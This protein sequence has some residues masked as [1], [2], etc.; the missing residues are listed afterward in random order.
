MD[1]LLKPGEPLN[2]RLLSRLVLPS[3][4]SLMPLANAGPPEPAAPVM[5]I[6]ERVAAAELVLC[7]QADAAPGVE[8]ET[9]LRLLGQGKTGL[10][11]LENEGPAANLAPTE[12]LGLEAIIEAD[13]SRPVLLVQDGGIDIDGPVLSSELGR[14]WRTAAAE[15]LDG[16]R[17]VAQSV[18]VI[19]LPAF[20]NMKVGTGFAIAP[21]LILT[22]RHVL[23][24]IARFDNRAWS[25]KFKAQIDFRGEFEH[26]GSLA[27]DLD[28]VV[29]FGPDPIGDRVNFANLDVAVIQVHGALDDFPPPLAFGDW[30]DAVKVT[31]TQAPSI[32]VMGFPVKPAATIAGGGQG[33]MEAPATGTEFDGVL[34]SLFDKRFGVKRWAPGYV[35]AGAGQ[36]ADDA[37]NWVMSHDASTLGG[38]SGSCVVDLSGK[39][40]LV[41]GLHFG[42]RPRVENWAH[43]MAAL[44]DRFAG[45][46]MKWSSAY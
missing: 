35:D 25:L 3:P 6:R 22:N 29:L 10:R 31:Q 44:R 18:G 39:N 13:G 15:R 27:F 4:E 2:H 36:L 8:R 37:Y 19:Q 11:K 1:D 42:G 21:G 46:E 32:Y 12:V 5:K 41:V 26:E 14:P 40:A 28:S 16:I 34:E 38:N 30:V 43:V 23:E 20:D 9:V 33:S 17:R 7:S 45:V 24:A